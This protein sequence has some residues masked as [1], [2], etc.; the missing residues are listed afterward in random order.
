MFSIYLDLAIELKNLWNVRVT[1][2]P[3]I[4]GALGTVL[5][6]LER[7]LEQLETI[8]RIGTI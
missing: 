1:G 3:I 7:G 6:G 5:K 2:I 4:I 8:V